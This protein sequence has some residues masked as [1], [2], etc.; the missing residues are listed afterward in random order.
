[1][2]SI[3]RYEIALDGSYITW[4]DVD[5]NITIM[6]LQSDP[7]LLSQDDLNALEQQITGGE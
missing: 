4:V 5:D 2:I 3:P 7:S 6:H 1:M